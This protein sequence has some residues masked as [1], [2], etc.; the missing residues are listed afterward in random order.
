MEKSKLTL[1]VEFYRESGENEPV[2][3]WLLTLP[4]PIKMIVDEDIS[5]VQYRWPLGMPLVRSLGDGIHEVRSNIPKW[6]YSD[7]VQSIR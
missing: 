7:F 5:K 3:E 4:K 2:R 6:D 1:N